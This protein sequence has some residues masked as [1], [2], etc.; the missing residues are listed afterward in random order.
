[1]GAIAPGVDR[2]HWPLVRVSAVMCFLPVGCAI[3]LASRLGLLPCIHH[4]GSGQ[5]FSTTGF[6]S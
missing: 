3:G 4:K 5:Q 6:Y 2:T 1:M